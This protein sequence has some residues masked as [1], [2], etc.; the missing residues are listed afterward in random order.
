IYSR[1]LTSRNGAIEEDWDDSSTE[2]L[3]V[4]S[5]ALAGLT[6]GHVLDIG[7][8]VVI[9]KGVDRAA[10]TISVHQ[11]GEGDTAV[12]SHA[13]GDA[14]DVI[15]FA[16]D[17][18]DLKNVESV[19]E[20]TREWS[21]YV[22]TVFETI[23]W[24]KHGELVRQGLDS[25][26]AVQVLVREAEIRVARMLSA[27]AIRGVKAQG[28]SSGGR[29][30]SAGLLAQLGDVDNRGARRFD[31][32]GDLTEAKFTAAL[33][34]LFDAGGSADTVWV[35][36]TVKAYINAFI[37]ADSSVALV[38]QKSNHTAGGIYVDSYNYEG[39][40][41]KVRVDSD[42]PSDRIA[43]VNQGKCKKG[44]LADDGLR[45]VDEPTLSSREKRKSIQG[46]IGFLV[47]DV[48][49]DHTLLY[50]ITGGTV[51]RVY[52]AQIVNSVDEP[53]YS[54]EVVSGEESADGG[55]D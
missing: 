52:K 6:I 41:L 12:A 34:D 27:M 10:G 3:S 1:T 17:D 29:Y 31:V 36:P 7:G 24:L 20:S 13:A 43:V 44:W 16:G 18:A 37:G 4:S 22:Q 28:T 14:F 11:R 54:Q 35:S 9:V 25:A 55:N 40:I 51:D 26:N 42:M 30:M 48:G 49:S 47:E 2:D 39:A 23:D 33:K 38:D 50:G 15:G 21:N 32:A 45:M 5:E 19:T 53:V 46:S 8:E